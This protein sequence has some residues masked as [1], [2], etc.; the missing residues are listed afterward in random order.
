M[1]FPSDLRYTKD[2]EWV[3]LDDDGLA[4][5]G[6]TDYAQ[7]ELGDIVFVELEAE[8]TEVDAESALGTVE[9]VKT[10]SELFAPIAGTIEAIN[11]DLDGAPESVNSDPYGD[12]W[13]VKV[14]P[15]NADD[16][17]GLLSADEYKVMIGA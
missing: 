4:V 7:G 2:H 10:V 16:V 8:G 15:A 6:I 12:G 13:M 17:A 9:A 5:I 3:R 14:R 11:E 1:D